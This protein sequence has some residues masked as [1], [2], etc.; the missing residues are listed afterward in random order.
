MHTLVENLTNGQSQKI[1]KEVQAILDEQGLW[2]TK[3]VHLSCDQPKCA[4][5]QTLA[6]CMVYVKGRKCDLCKETKEYSGRCT[7]QRLCDAYDNQKI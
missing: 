6:T 5:C 2:P 1:Q 3:G 7:K 4:N